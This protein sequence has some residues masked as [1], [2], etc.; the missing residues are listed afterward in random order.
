[1]PKNKSQLNREIAQA[2]GLPEEVLKK[3]RARTTAYKRAITALEVSY[4]DTAFRAAVQARR[5]L[6]KAL[7]EAAAHVP[8][9]PGRSPFLSEAIQTLERERKELVSNTLA[10]AEHRGREA[11]RQRHHEASTRLRDEQRAANRELS[12]MR[13]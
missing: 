11:N 13:R 4:G 10:Q 6:D 5:A 3:W 2:I 12:W 7:D 1:M 9:V 8:Y